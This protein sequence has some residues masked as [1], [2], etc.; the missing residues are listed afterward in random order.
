MNRIAVDID[1]TLV[2]FLPN[3]AKFHNKKLPNGKYRY[4]YRNIFGVEEKVSKSMVID[5]YNSDA[6]H[7]L[8][9][10]EGSQEKLVELRERASKLYIVTGRQYYVRQRTE[11][12]IHK[13]FPDIFDDIVITN[14]FT[15]HEVPKVD[16]FKCLNIDTV[17]DDD[18][19]VCIESALSGIKPYNY[20]HFPEYPWYEPHEYT[21][22]S[23][24]K[25]EELEII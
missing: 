11:D 5:F 6:F 19:K 17:I 20:T 25:W 21:D 9:P 3:L 8:K 18:S 16:I 13:Y 10:I 22:F 1:E 12:W 15:Q 14:S 7:E 2:H 23:L 4:L 24:R